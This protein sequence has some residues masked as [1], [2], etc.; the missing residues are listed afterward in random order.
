MNLRPRFE[1]Q[2][3]AAF[4]AAVL[5]VAVLIAATSELARDAVDATRWVEHTYEVINDLDHIKADSLQIELSVQNYRLTG[6]PARIAE[7]DA[8]IAAREI[9]LRR[10]R[11][12]VADDARQ[13]ERW[14]QLREVIDEHLAIARRSEFLRK[15][16]GPEAAAA[17]TASAPL[18]ETRERMYQ[19]LAEMEQ[20]GRR[21]LEQHDAERQRM[22][23]ATVA[24]GVL[25]LLALVALLAATYVLIR[26]QVRA[27]EASRRALAESNEL[28]ERH[29]CERTAQLRES[30]EKQR[31]FV[32]HAPF[33]IAMLDRNMRYLAFSHRWLTDYNLGD[34]DITGRSH[35][36]LFPDLPERWKEIHRRCLAGAVEKADEDP[37]PRGDGSVDWV[38]WEVHPWPASDGRIGG[39]IVF[40]EVITERKQTE[41][42]LQKSEERFRLLVEGAK[43]Y[44]II[45]L[46]PQGHVLTW[47]EGARRLKGYAKA[48]IIGHPM[49]RFYSPEDIASGKPARLLAQAAAEGRCEDEGWRVRKDG[50]RFYADMIL[51]VIRNQAGELGGFAKITR[52]ITEKRRAEEALHASEVRYRRLFESAKDG[53]LILDAETGMIVDVN[54]FLIEML[55]YSHEAFLQKKLWEVGFFHDI[56]A[57]QA[58]FAELQAKEYIRYENKALETA[59]GRRIEVEFVSNVY[60]VNDRKVIQ[61]NIRD[62]T[63]RK[64]VEAALELE[65][66][67]LAAAFENVDVGLV[68]CDAQGGD[69]SM[70]AAALKFHGFTSTDDMLRR[71]GEYADEWEL[72]YPDDRI[73]PYDEWPLLRA[74]RGDYVR[75]YDTHLRN[76][77]T[78]HKWACSYTSA[79][80][81]N[82][83]GDVIL[84]VMTLLDITER[85]RAKENI[86]QLNAELEQRVHDLA[87]VNRALKTLNAGNHT[88]LHATDEQGLLDS[89]CRAIVDAGGYHMALVC[90]RNDDA[91]GTLRPMAESGYPGGLA[92]LQALEL[93]WEDDEHGL[94]MLGS[95][96]RSGQ[97]SVVRNMLN[98]PN[99]A[100]WRPHLQGNASGV[101]C[102]LRVNSEII[103][104]LA[105]YAAEPDAFG[106]DEMKLL[107]ESA[108]D[109]AF[110]IATLR[111]RVEQQNTQAAMQRLARYDAL[112]GLPNEIQFT[113]SITA[114]IDTSMRLNQSFALL[115]INIERLREINDALGFSHGD[116]LLREFGVR[117]NIAAPKPAVV[118]RLR[119]DEFVILL[120]DSKA[121]TACEMVQQ[122]E[123]V[124]ARPFLIAD[125]PLDVQSKIGIAL[126]PEHGSTPHDLFRR[127]D[128]ALQQARKKGVGHAVFDPGLNPDQPRRLA[129]AGEL[130]RAIDG[131]DLLLYLQ[132]KVDIATGRVCG[133]E[134][135][136]RWKHAERGLIPPDEFIGLAEHTGLIKPLTEWVIEESLRLNHA[137]QHE[138]CALP[139][140]VNLSA[141]NLREEDLLE[142]IRR[143]Q[144]TWSGGA[145][146]LELEITESAVMDDPEYALRVL[147]S[148]RDDGIPLYID[149]FGTGYSSLSYL[150]KMP[151]DYIKIDQS[152]V[153]AMTTS[154]ESLAIVRSTIDLAH[155]L[156]LKVVAEGI[157]TQENWNQLAA[158]G[159]GIGQGYFMSKPIPAE[160]FQNWV[161]Q[162]RPPVTTH[163]EEPDPQQSGRGQ[164]KGA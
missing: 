110:G 93:C 28:L 126:F 34:Q 143:M 52:D 49:E 104:A 162:F 127:M 135:L 140:A 35:Y 128:M 79:P 42:E 158:L 1:N 13:Q 151:V 155:D 102:P 78:G 18:R 14:A 109:L 146:L 8:A 96:I 61:C 7:R 83:A 50:S 139:I 103:G 45:M 108:D 144:S 156:G 159:C 15:T 94:G 62:V 98:D 87:H 9:T 2:V 124:L 46:D 74:M 77:K 84:I 56:V 114:A 90:Y 65:R 95:A 152:F 51:T 153:S 48:E 134:G 118:A 32:Y 37:F 141:R 160:A 161:R 164:A 38:R 3:L 147:H 115:Q 31:L 107:T 105:I 67:K 54:P 149:D 19:L 75:D 76:I 138:G 27:T 117:L 97:T 58:N 4:A 148:L 112:T 106:P 41:I 92:T 39:I 120:P 26:R 116:Q 91:S 33:A 89:M 40:S 20:E 88:L 11:E 125:I 80:V 70:N 47:N 86:Q 101:A 119:G 66:S 43:D 6:D 64:R 22:R 23:Q 24:A 25:V 29:V 132:P 129:M 163:P 137:W 16:Q 73:M 63:E 100:P 44:A 82:S 150:Q 122:V 69:I 30:E 60:R 17:Y 131:G 121:Q 157:E 10:I 71:V 136:V 21:L 53:I 5:V 59:D 85:K 130:R 113:E 81:R 111:A 154:K 123:A 145:S 72:R 68:I 36:E 57:N 99:Y 133:A 55:G 142:K 12:L